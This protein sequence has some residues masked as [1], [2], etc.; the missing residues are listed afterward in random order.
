MLCVA[1]GVLIESRW[2]RIKRYRLN[3]LPAGSR[4]S[5]TLLHLSDLH[6]VSRDRKKAA[7]LAGLPRTDITVVTGDFLAEPQAVETA[8]AALRPVR[9]IQASYFVLGSN[10][11]YVPAPLNYFSYF[12]RSRKPHR[13]ARGRSAELI[14]QLQADGWTPLINERLDA[15]WNGVSAEV[16]GLDDPHIHR[17]DLRA[18]PRRTAAQGSFGLAIAHSPEPSPELAALGYDLVVA[19]HTHGG[20]VR[21]PG[22]G[23]LV[24]NSLLPRRISR[25]LLRL[26]PTYVHISPGMGTSKYAPFR[27]FCRPEATILELGQRS[28]EP[29]RTNN[30]SEATAV[31]AT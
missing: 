20:Q 24:N 29:K 15:Q 5:L 31:Q 7:F 21:M 10:D 25:G 27:F 3:I 4:G 2:Y 19:G 16:C 1:Y 26:G 22:Y 13:G 11:Y 14:G 23:A 8:V 30:T 18:A 9:G 12:K 28:S 6:F 17:D